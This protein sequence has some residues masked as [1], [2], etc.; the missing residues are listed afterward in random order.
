MS[1]QETRFTPNTPATPPLN[2]PIHRAED[3]L[4][5][6]DTAFIVLGD[7]TYTLRRTRAGKLILTK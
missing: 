2:S 3:L 6:S 5:N 4:L 7:Q 1:L